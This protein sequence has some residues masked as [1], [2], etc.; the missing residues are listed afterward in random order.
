MGSPRQEFWLADH[1]RETGCGVGIGVGGSF[2]V[3]SGRVAR[4][5]RSC[6]AMRLEWLYRFVKE[7]RRWRGQLALPHLRAR[8]TGSTPTVKA[9][10]LREASQRGSTR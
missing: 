1:L 7:P 4:A 8:R 10:I 5:P 2:D 9:M 3:I 6:S